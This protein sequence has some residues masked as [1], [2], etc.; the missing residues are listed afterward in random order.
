MMA[1]LWENCSIV[2]LPQSQENAFVM[3]CGYFNSSFFMIFPP[4]K[5]QVEDILR[6]FP[7]LNTPH[8]TRVHFTSGITS[9][10]PDP[11]DQAFADFY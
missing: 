7:G 4:I 10:H 9:M 11:C 3:F 8:I 1:L 5:L 6:S 2:D